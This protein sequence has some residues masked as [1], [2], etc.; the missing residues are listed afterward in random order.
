MALKQT[1]AGDLVGYTILVRSDGNPATTPQ[2]GQVSGGSNT[3]II[4]PTV[5][6]TPAYTPNDNVGGKL[7]LANAVGA[8]G[9]LSVLQSVK[10]LDR[11]NQKAA[12][13]ILLFGD[14]LAS[15]LTDNAQPTISDA[16][17][18][19]LIGQ[20]TIGASDYVTVDHAGTDFAIAEK[21]IS[22]TVSP[23]AG[24][25]LYAAIITTGGPTYATAGALTLRFGLLYA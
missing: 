16:D 14:D 7:T 15:T 12:L 18:S 23:A 13:T 8:A 20:V 25:T 21:V 1:P 22:T 2:L 11:S 17:I 3:I 5:S 9:G 4:T 24:T 19:K 10:V 6:T